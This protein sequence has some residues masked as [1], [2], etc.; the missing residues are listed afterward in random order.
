MRIFV[1]PEV[2][3][4]IVMRNGIGFCDDLWQDSVNEGVSGDCE[5]SLLEDAT[6]RCSHARQE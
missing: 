6:H 5:E 4:V 3:Q 2:I 1:E